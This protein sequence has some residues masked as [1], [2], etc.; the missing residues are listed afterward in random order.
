MGFIFSSFAGLIKLSSVFVILF[1][2][3]IFFSSVIFWYS[4]LKF[5]NLFDFSLNFGKLFISKSFSELFMLESFRKLSISKSF[6]EL[7]ILESFRKLSISKSF[8]EL[9]IL[10]SFRKLS[11]SKYFSELSILESFGAKVLTLLSFFFYT[12]RYFS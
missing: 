7:F 1:R 10:E 3:G 4:S 8:S 11:I 5:F 6:S 12:F 2:L 9:F